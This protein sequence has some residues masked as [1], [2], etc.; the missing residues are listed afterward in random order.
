MSFLLASFILILFQKM[1]WKNLKF[2]S[3]FCFS[4]TVELGTIQKNFGDDL[5]YELNFWYK[6][7]SSSN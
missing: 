7:I 6:K 3:N 5:L 1:E 4:M 2:H